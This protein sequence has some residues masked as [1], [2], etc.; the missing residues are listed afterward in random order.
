[1]KEK[2]KKK[3]WSSSHGKVM[4]KIEIIV[5]N[6]WKTGKNEFVYLWIAGL[7]RLGFYDVG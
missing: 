2:R 6:K 1:M 4:D 7:E 5:I 3:S